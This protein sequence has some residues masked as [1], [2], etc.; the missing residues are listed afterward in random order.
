[1]SAPC[2]GGGGG[3]GSLSRANSSASLS[4]GTGERW[5]GDRYRSLPLGS[6]ILGMYGFD[7]G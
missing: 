5:W 6:N 1:M 7:T 2:G 4:G 3:D